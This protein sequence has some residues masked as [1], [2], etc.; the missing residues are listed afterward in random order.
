MATLNAIIDTLISRYRFGES[1]GQ[2]IWSGMLS[3]GTGLGG[4]SR[5]V[6][7][8]RAPGHRQRLRVEIEDVTDGGPARWENLPRLTFTGQVIAKTL[9]LYPPGGCS[10]MPAPCSR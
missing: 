10:P 8:V 2:D 4:C 1:G 5:P 3:A 9:W 7:P 6:A